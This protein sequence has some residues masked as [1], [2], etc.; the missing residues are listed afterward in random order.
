[1]K[2]TTAGPVMGE[3]VFG[4]EV[5]AVEFCKRAACPLSHHYYLSDRLVSRADHTEQAFINHQ[6]LPVRPPLPSVQLALG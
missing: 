3:R 6:R 4:F 1:M 2:E 5:L